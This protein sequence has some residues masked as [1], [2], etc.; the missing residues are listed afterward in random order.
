[1]EVFTFSKAF[2]RGSFCHRASALHLYDNVPT[3]VGNYLKVRD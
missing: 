2:L 3:N 1:M